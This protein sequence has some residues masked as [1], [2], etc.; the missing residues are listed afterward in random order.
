MDCRVNL[1]IP[2]LSLTDVRVR[3]G[4]QHFGP[5]NFSMTAGERIAILGPSG[6]GKS[7][8]LKVLARELP[9]ERG[10]ALL[11]KRVLSDWRVAELSRC[12][13]V[14]PQSHE[15]AFGLPTDLVIGLGRVARMHDPKLSDIIRLAAEL[16]CASHLL[17]RRFDSL[18]GGEKARVQLARVFAQLWDAE[19]GMVL[20]DE[21]LAALDPGLQFQLMDAIEEF[22]AERGHSVLAVLHDVNHALRGFERLLLIKGGQLIGD[23]PS[24]ADAIPHLESLYDVRLST[25]VCATGEML[26]SPVRGRRAMGALA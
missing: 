13:A 17:G 4:A 26:V 2:L 18:S 6:A 15:V 22:A 1:P 12:R 8:L 5:F 14:L 16:A 10:D 11:N 23:L 20:V 3:L 19:Q 7:T 9:Y 21:P 25:A 24:N